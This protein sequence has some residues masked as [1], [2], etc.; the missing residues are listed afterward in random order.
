METSQ[1]SAMFF[2]SKIIERLLAFKKTA[3]QYDPMFG[4]DPAVF[5]DP[6]VEPV[7]KEEALPVPG[8]V[9]E[10]VDEEEALPGP[11]KKQRVGQKDNVDDESTQLHKDNV[12]DESTQLQKDNVDDEW[13]RAAL[14]T[15]WMMSGRWL[16]W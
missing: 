4:F 11:A 9:V 16:C 7:Y 15:T 2:L 13:F 14:R 6:A 12:D 8:S 3:K 5:F 1:K 10:P